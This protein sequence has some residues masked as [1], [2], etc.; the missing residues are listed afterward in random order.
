[1]YN[2]NDNNNDDNDDNNNN[3]ISSNISFR[4]SPFSGS[5]VAQQRSVVRH[6]AALRCVA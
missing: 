5:S 2:D 3:I 1:M 6:R 4:S